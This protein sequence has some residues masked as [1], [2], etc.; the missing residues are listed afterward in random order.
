MYAIFTT[1]FNHSYDSR[2]LIGVATSK[3]K[4]INLVCQHAAHHQ[5]WGLSEWAK[6]FLSINNQTQGN[7]DDNTEYEFEYVLEKIEANTLL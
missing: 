7:G 2:D 5:A 3:R 6:G 4:A 1:D